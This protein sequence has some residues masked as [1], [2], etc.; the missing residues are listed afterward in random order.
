MYPSGLGHK[1]RVSGCMERGT[2]SYKCYAIKIYEALWDDAV[3]KLFCFLLG[4]F[5]AHTM[6]SLNYGYFVCPSRLELVF[7]S[8]TP[9]WLSWGR[10]DGFTTSP[11]TLWLAFSQG[12]TCGSAGRT[13]KKCVNWLDCC[14][15]DDNTRHLNMVPLLGSL[16]YMQ[17][18]AFI[19]SSAIS[20]FSA[21]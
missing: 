1:P 3:T 7:P 2:V 17:M 18:A 9:S 11:D 20:I 15:A 16:V 19:H 14:T 5:I 8:L 21:S 4:D 13:G 6:T 10:R 12:E